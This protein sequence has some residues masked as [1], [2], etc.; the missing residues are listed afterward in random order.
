MR[1]IRWDDGTRYDDVNA[2]W[3]D[4]GSYLLE[5]GDPGH[6]NTTP[7]DGSSKKKEPKP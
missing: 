4:S 6:V 1:P 5:S 2:R 3:G 7:G